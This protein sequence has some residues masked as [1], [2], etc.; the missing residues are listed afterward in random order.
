MFAHSVVFS[1]HCAQFSLVVTAVIG[2]NFGPHGITLPF[3]EVFKADGQSR[4]ALSEHS[5][6][7]FVPYC[8]IYCSAS[9]AGVQR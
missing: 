1:I 5:Q 3:R 9:Q 6:E 7:L 2:T 8:I 4:V